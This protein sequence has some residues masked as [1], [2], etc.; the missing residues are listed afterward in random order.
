M[1]RYRE[2]PQTM[3][4]AQGTPVRIRGELEAVGAVLGVVRFVKDGKPRTVVR[5]PNELGGG[6]YVSIPTADLEVVQ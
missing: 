4:L 5:F 1:R 6:N 2:T 3:E